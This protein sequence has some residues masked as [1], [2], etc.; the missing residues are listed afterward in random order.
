MRVEF[1]RAVFSDQPRE[2]SHSIKIVNYSAEVS[3]RTEGVAAMTNLVPAADRRT[4]LTN[5]ST[6]I[7]TVTRALFSACTARIQFKELDYRITFGKGK[8]I[9]RSF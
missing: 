4:L 3:G 8:G 1:I 7:L 6:A 2:R 9:D 5:A